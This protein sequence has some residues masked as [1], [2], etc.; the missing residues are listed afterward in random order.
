MKRHESIV[1]L[2]RDHHFGLLFCWKIRQG[3][4]KNVAPERI[5]PY[6]NYFWESHLRQHFEEEEKFLFLAAKGALTQQAIDEHKAIEAVVAKAHI[7][8]A[9]TA[10]E[11]SAI[12]D[13]VDSHIRFEERVLFPQIENTL[14]EAELEQINEQLK[15]HH[16]LPDKEDYHDE[17]WL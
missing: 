15:V 3:L 16:Q 10:E 4:K 2:S 13:M 9:I 1:V 7:T 6:I 14:T 12:A 5:Q 11:L 8:T 17:F